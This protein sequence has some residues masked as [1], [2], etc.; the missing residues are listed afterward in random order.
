MT[1][2]LV[3]GELVDLTPEEEA[4]CKADYLADQAHIE[5]NRVLNEII[6]LEASITL[7]RTREAILG[8]DNG[9]LAE[10]EAAIAALRAQL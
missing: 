4:Q 8:T 9:W 5:A 6:A 1:Q 3:N 7:R 10:Q 2:K